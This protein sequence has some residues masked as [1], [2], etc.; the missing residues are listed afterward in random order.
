M[1]AAELI[2]YMIPPLK[3]SD[4][5]D[6]AVA[7]M[8]ELRCDQLPV[9]D[10][11]KFLGLVS[12]EQILEQNDL[13]IN[14]S[15]LDLQF[16]EC[17][18]LESQHFYDVVKTASD[19]NVQLVAVLNEEDQYTGVIS[20][21]DTVSSFAQTAAVQSP[22]G[23]LVISM[24]VRDYFLSE[25][26]RLIEE[27]GAKILGSMIREDAHDPKRLKLTIKINQSN[28]STIVA[29]LE[30]F[31]YKIIGR[32][33]EPHIESNDRERLDIFFRYLDI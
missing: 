4:T 29:T 10:E 5:A 26:S 6:K 32:F 2:N 8:E 12:E 27:E 13:D 24:E 7:W 20:V 11:G 33:Q 16:D 15:G 1:I 31:N 22:G 9:V 19:H 17:T 23:I 18:V 25:I 28:L 30:R 3:M 14:I 21:Q